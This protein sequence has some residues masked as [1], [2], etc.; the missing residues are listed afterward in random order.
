MA[1]PSMPKITW[2]RFVEM[3]D[4]LHSSVS[5]MSVEQLD[6]LQYMPRLC[7]V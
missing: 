6:A 2:E 1:R 5:D 4:A 7:C 3:L